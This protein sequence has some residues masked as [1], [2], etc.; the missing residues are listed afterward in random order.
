MRRYPAFAVHAPAEFAAM[1]A[2]GGD[3]EGTDAAAEAL[4][5]HIIARPA[6]ALRRSAFGDA[7]EGGLGGWRGGEAPLTEDEVVLGDSHQYAPAWARAGG[8]ESAPAE[9]A[10]PAEAEAVK[11][12][13]PGRAKPPPPITPGYR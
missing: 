4:G 5:I 9:P 1:M 10:E 12:A 8:G 11:E 2:P 7:A 3:E 13:S 6:A